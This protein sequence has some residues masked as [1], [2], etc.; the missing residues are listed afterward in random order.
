MNACMIDG[1]GGGMPAAALLLPLV[2]LGRVV[3]VLYVEGGEKALGERF[4]E[5]HRLLAKTALAF[6]ILI[7][8][9][10]ILMI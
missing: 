6:E 3:N 1:L 8:R 10:K 2:I 7:F 5:L 9:E 4:V